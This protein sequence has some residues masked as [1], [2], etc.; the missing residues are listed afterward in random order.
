MSLLVN[1][2]YLLTRENIYPEY[3][4]YCVKIKKK[5]NFIVFFFSAFSETYY[6][7]F[8]SFYL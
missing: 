1:Y 8:I 6:R 7:V 4:L 2:L 5:P 3:E